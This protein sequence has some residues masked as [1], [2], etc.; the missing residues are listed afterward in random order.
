MMRSRSFGCTATSLLLNHAGGSFHFGYIRRSQMLSVFRSHLPDEQLITYDEND[1]PEEVLAAAEAKTTTLLQWFELNKRDPNACQYLYQETPAHYTWNK[2]KWNLHQKYTTIGVTIGRMYQAAPSSGE[3]FY[4]RLLLTAVTGAQSFQHLRTVNNVE[5]ATFK[6]ACIAMGLLENDNEWRQCLQE[7]AIMQSGAQLRSLFVTLLLF[8]QPAKPDELWEEFKENI[9]DDLAHKLR[10]CDVPNPTDAQ[11]YDFG[12]H[13]I[14][15]LLQSHGCCLSEWTE[16]PAS[17]MDWAAYEDNPLLAAQLAYD[18]PSLQQLVANNLQTFNEEQKTAYNT[19][20]DSAMNERGKLVILHSAGGGGK[21]F[22]CN[23]IAAA[24]HAEGK[25]AL[26]CASSG[27]SAILLVG[28]RTSHS[29]FKIPIL[30]R[31]DTTCSI[32]RGTHLAEL[33]CRTSLIIWDEVPMQNWHDIET[34]DCTLRDVC[35]KDVPFGGKTVLF[36]G[37]CPYSESL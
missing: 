14:N 11:L 4:L 9:C 2:R 6:E 12:L 29:T 33:L 8:C 21:T 19:V 37:M 7:A 20:F 3:R 5:C 34:V 30:S 18:I 32:R 28:G 27:I 15:K 36:G 24:V 35:N 22:V 13:L 17:I 31:D 25:I 10:Q 1:S 23:T 26:T 16:M